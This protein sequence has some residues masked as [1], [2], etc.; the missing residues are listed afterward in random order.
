MTRCAIGGVAMLEER[1]GLWQDPRPMTNTE[2]VRQIKR[3][4]NRKLY[5][6]EESRYITLEEIAKLV[7]DGEHIRVTDNTTNADLTSLTLAQIIYEE[8]KKMKRVVP[9]AALR[10]VI[11]SGGDFIQRRVTEPINT[12]REEAE[13]T[14]NRLIK[15]ERDGIEEMMHVV[16]EWID[17]TQTAMEDVQKRLDDRIRLVV[18]ALPYLRKN[19]EDILVLEKRICELEERLR[20]LEEHAGRPASPGPDQTP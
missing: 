13:R 7:K 20:E 18:N 17:T 3:Y 11:Q 4:A 19:E 2:P 1:R 10:Q 6:L 16:K 12:L 14:V 8:E 5:D 9:L 15:R